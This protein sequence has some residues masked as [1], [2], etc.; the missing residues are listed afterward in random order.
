MKNYILIL[1]AFVALS[2]SAQLIHQSQN[3]KGQVLITDG[4]V[5]GIGAT[6]EQCALLQLDALEK[7]LLLTRTAGA[8]AEAMQPVPGIIVYITN[9]DGVFINSIG[10]WGYTDHGEG[11]TWRKFVMTP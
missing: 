6:N 8:N 9:G 2:G 11:G 10:Y 3:T 4:S 5:V 7:C 1:F